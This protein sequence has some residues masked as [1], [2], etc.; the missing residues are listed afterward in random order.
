[1]HGVDWD[2]SEEEWW[3]Q[4]ETTVAVYSHS[5][6]ARL[7]SAPRFLVFGLESSRLGSQSGGGDQR[8]GAH[9]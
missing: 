8:I 5:A 4:K 2:S 3:G 1:M 7:S 6:T 9:F